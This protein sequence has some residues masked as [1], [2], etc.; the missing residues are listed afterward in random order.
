MDPDSSATANSPARRN[1]FA[2]ASQYDV[3]RSAFFASGFDSGNSSPQSDA[4]STSRE[5][6]YAFPDTLSSTSASDTS[7]SVL[8]QGSFGR[9]RVSTGVSRA[10]VPLSS[11]DSWD[12][13]RQRAFPNLL[14]HSGYIPSYIDR[15][16]DLAKSRSIMLR[17]A[18]EAVRTA[19][20]TAY[21]DQI[22]MYSS[23]MICALKHGLIPHQPQVTPSRAL[24]LL[25]VSLEDD[26]CRMTRFA[27][28]LPGFNDF[29]Y[30]DQKILLTEKYMVLKMIHV[31]RYYCKGEFYYYL[32]CPEKVHF[33]VSLVEIMGFDMSVLRFCTTF[34]MA[35]NDICLTLNEA[36]LLAAVAM[37][38]PDVSNVS[39]KALMV[40]QHAFYLDALFYSLGCR[41]EIAD[42]TVAYE[43]V[44]WVMKFFP[45]IDKV[46]MGYIASLDYSS[47]PVR[48]RSLQ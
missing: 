33:P 9:F 5:V 39:N 40:Q 21:G 44:E 26:I 7:D 22:E 2:D 6:Q 17:Q 36:Y 15:Y 29:C 30:A 37:F 34:Y 16:F 31:A 11:L 14:K 20:E 32:S 35:C 38:A 25:S 43:R 24:R 12:R 18:A 3:G 45:P 1:S 8:A 27:S 10:L 46:S 42:R 48:S 19:Y 41:L 4:R 28:M 13:E 23:L 47:Y